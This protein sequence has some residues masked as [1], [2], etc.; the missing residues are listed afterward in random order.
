MK[1]K[2]LKELLNDFPDDYDIILQKD[3]EGNGYSPLSCGEE[4]MYIPETTWHGEVYDIK[5]SAED[6][7]RGVDEWEWMKQNKK[8]RCVVLAPTN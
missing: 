4:A 8:F 5:W 1:V 2:E 7:G 3:S 6:A